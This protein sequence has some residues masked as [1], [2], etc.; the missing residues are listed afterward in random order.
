MAEKYKLLYNLY[1]YKIMDITDIKLIY[2]SLLRVTPDSV[3]IGVVY[4]ILQI[5]IA[6]YCMDQNGK[7]NQ[8]ANC[9]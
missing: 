2:E 7:S 3:L 5:E 8:F 9:N 1:N 4:S 6:V